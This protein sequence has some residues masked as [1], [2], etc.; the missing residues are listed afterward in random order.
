MLVFWL[1][2]LRVARCLLKAVCV[3]CVVCVVRC[4]RCVVGCMLYATC[5]LLC[6]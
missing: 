6:A 4:S 2:L 3:V 1:L 5:C